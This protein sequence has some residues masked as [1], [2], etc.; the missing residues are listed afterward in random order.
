[1][2]LETDDGVSA[3]FLTQ[4]LPCVFSCLRFSYDTEYIFKRGYNIGGLQD[5]KHGSLFSDSLL[6]Q[7]HWAKTTYF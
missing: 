7:L 5:E 3:F 4:E 6:V 2:P 1:M